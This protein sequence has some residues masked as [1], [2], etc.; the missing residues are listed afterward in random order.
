MTRLR[1]SDDPA[2]INAADFQQRFRNATA[3]MTP[4]PIPK[5][6]VYPCCKRNRTTTQFDD[7]LKSCKACR[8]PR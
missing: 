3:N 8:Q 5:M 6:R 1:R 4:Y 7:G 2:P